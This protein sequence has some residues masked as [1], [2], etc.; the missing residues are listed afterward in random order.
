M[1]LRDE[2]IIVKAEKYSIIPSKVINNLSQEKSQNYWNELVQV[3]CDHSN[4]HFY[5]LGLKLKYLQ[6]LK[7]KLSVCN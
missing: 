5:Y 6:S 2:L 1:E 4:V 3:S 7:R